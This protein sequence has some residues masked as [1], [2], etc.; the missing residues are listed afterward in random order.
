MCVCERERDSVCVCEYLAHP[1]AE[2]H[3]ACGVPTVRSLF[4]QESVMVVYVVYVVIYDIF[5]YVVYVVTHDSIRCRRG[6]IR[7]WAGD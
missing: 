3:R 5:V 6:D 7:L 1:A 2:L 4:A